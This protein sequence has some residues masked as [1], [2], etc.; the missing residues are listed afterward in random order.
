MDQQLANL[1]IEL[2]ELNPSFPRI[3]NRDLRL[4]PSHA[5]VSSPNAPASNLLASGIR[6]V[7]DTDL[8]FTT[9]AFSC[10]H[11]DLPI[12]LGD[13]HEI[14]AAILPQNETLQTCLRQ[15]SNAVQEIATV[16]MNETNEAGNLVIF[17][18]EGIILNDHQI[19]I[20]G[21]SYHL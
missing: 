18:E 21:N 1:M 3:S 2:T 13:M 7:L 19:D 12:P 20:L 5:F 17:N 4:I 8:E 15:R 11:Q 10:D 14:I 16:S 9:P 6:H